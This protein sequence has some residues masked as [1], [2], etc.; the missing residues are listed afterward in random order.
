MRELWPG[1]GTVVRVHRPGCARSLTTHVPVL[2]SGWARRDRLST[3]RLC[4][5]VRN[6]S[7]TE[8][9]LASRLAG[10]AGPACGSG[11]W[12]GPVDRA[13]GTVVATGDRIAARACAVYRKCGYRKCS[14]RKCSLAGAPVT[15]CHYREGQYREGQ[16]REGQYREGQYRERQYRESQYRESQYRE[17]QYRE[18]SSRECR[19]P[20]VRVPGL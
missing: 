2:I 7:C 6:I 20:G 3:P 1:Q 15:W 17:S 19:V 9:A 5:R 10:V 8:P 18:R 16:Y 13:R 12:I 11:L 14:Y 4:A